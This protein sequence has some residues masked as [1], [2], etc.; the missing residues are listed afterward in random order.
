MQYLISGY[1]GEGNVGDEAILAGIIQELRRRDGAAD[2][3]VMSFDPED[4]V[5]RHQVASI[6]TSLRKP[7]A[8]L[9]A[10][11]SSDLLISGGGSILHEADFALYGRSF[12]LREGKLRPIPYFLS[13]VLLAQTVRLPVMWYAQGLG[14]LE[15]WQARRAV[16][17]AGS[18]CVAVTWRDPASARLASEVG[19]KAPIQAVVPDPAYGLVP[20]DGVRVREVLLERGIRLGRRFVAVSP[21]PWLA[22]SAYREHLAAVLGRVAEDELMDVLF[23]P[24]Q[25]RTDGPLCD[26]LAGH[27]SLTGKAHVVHGIEDAATLEGILGAAALAVTMRLHACILAAAAG[28]PVVALDYDPK[29]RAFAAQTGQE[30]FTVS[31]DELEADGGEAALE[32]AVV[33]TTRNLGARRAALRRAVVP[34][35][36]GAGRTAGLAVQ[37]AAA[38]GV[39]GMRPDQMRRLWKSA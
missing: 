30:A 23:V 22:R 2:I 8:L 3:T 14:P 33:A 36:E 17:A 21:R 24:F 10:L 26:E 39:P 15:T 38:H 27:R 37:L 13:V 29:V 32:K 31:V 5:T 28:T 4:T 34:L 12:L 1:Y 18:G 9:A 11:R 19:V 6:S 7:G 16:A 35:R 20:R 25:E